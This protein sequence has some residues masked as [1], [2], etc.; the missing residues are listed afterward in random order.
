MDT[1]PTASSLAGVAQRFP[2]HSLTPLVTVHMDHLLDKAPVT[3]TS[4]PRSKL[5][6]LHCCPRLTG[7]GAERQLIYLTTYWA[8]AGHDV[9]IAYLA[10]SEVP[11][12]LSG[13]GVALHPLPHWTPHDP[14]LLWRL[15]RLVR[16]TKPHVVQTWLLQM[17]VLGGLAA[18]LSGTPWLLRE[19]ADRDA[20]PNGIKTRMRLSVASTADAIVSNSFGGDA[21]WAEHRPPSD[22]FV[23]RNAVPAEPASGIPPASPQSLG[24]PG[25]CPIVMFAGR[26]VPQKNLMTLVR[27]LKRVTVET[28]AVAVIVGTGE[29]R[30]ALDALIAELGLDGRVFLCGPLPTIWPVLKRADLFVSISNFEGCPNVVLEAMVCRCPLVVSDIPAHREVLD[31]NAAIFVSRRDDPDSVAE[32][33]I[34]GLRDRAAAMRRADSAWQR[35]TAWKISDVAS[36]YERIYGIVLDRRCPVRPA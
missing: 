19:P 17:D 5:R 8:A 23:V 10:G 9:H 22:R 33:I 3:A 35:T 7:G 16:A 29:L 31:S 15:L 30:P 13:S 4:P 26:L 32:A 6:M 12:A 14:R 2:K 21:Y 34:D 20:W 24:L 36:A 28:P 27:A 25:R 1:A 18:T 11:S